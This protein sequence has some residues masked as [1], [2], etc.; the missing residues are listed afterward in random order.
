MVSMTDL[1]E[2]KQQSFAG[3]EGVEYGYAN[4]TG[5]TADV[6]IPETELWD[7]QETQIEDIVKGKQELHRK[8]L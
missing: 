7:A 6:V 1:S 4:L 2:K 5:E 3:G 8:I